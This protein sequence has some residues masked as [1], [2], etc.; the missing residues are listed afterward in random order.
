MEI[1]WTFIKQDFN[2]HIFKLGVLYQRHIVREWA[3]RVISE[4]VWRQR[5]NEKN[6]LQNGDHK[7]FEIPR[8]LWTMNLIQIKF[9]VRYVL[10]SIY[11]PLKKYLLLFM[12]INSCLFKQTDR[13]HKQTLWWKDKYFNVEFMWYV[14]WPLWLK[15][16]EGLT[17]FVAVYVDILSPHNFSK[18]NKLS[19]KNHGTEDIA[20]VSTF[21]DLFKNSRVSWK[22][23]THHRV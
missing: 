21:L 19:N 16:P 8:A 13:K 9:K 2:S 20:D 23:R 7:S 1:I 6:W 14:W 22:R 12:K 3:L 17:F 15:G 11:F 18:R 4:C 5:K 10:H